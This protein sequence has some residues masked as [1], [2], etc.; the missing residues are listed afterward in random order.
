[1]DK[2][3]LDNYASVFKKIALVWIGLLIPCF[4]LSIWWIIYETRAISIIIIEFLSVAAL[5]VCIYYLKYIVLDNKP[6]KTMIIV[7]GFILCE[8]I[9]LATWISILFKEDAGIANLVTIWVCCFFILFSYLC[10]ILPVGVVF[11]NVRSEDLAKAQNIGGKIVVP[12]PIP[13][14]SGQDNEI[15]VTLK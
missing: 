9:G 12:S 10:F 1:M 3:G 6:V 8:Q 11:W 15:V 4:G 2:L 13:V 5:L 14:S 7:M